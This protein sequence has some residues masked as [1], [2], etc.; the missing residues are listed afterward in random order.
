MHVFEFIFSSLNFELGF[1]SFQ[2]ML[3]NYSSEF[4]NLSY[5]KYSSDLRQSSAL[6]RRYHLITNILTHD[7]DDDIDLKEKNDK[8]NHL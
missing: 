1:I 6:F 8:I 7:D 4:R 5:T 2:F 3:S